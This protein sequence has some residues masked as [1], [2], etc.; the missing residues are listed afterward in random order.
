ME[1]PEQTLKLLAQYQKQPTTQPGEDDDFKAPTLHLKTKQS[2]RALTGHFFE[3]P[4]FEAYRL[5]DFRE[6]ITFDM[7]EEGVKVVAVL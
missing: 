7:D 4:G 2:F 3:N 1:T 5:V 6:S